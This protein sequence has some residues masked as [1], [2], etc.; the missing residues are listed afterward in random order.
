MLIWSLHTLVVHKWWMEMRVFE[1]IEQFMVY[2]LHI[3]E[4]SVGVGV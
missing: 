3:L 1:D 4:I 2:Q